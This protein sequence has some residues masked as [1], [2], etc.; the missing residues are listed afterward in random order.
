MKKKNGFF[1]LS[2]VIA[3]FMFLMCTCKKETRNLLVP[4]LDSITVIKITQSTSI[5]KSKILSNNQIGI[6]EKGFCYGTIPKPTVS[7]NKIVAKNLGKMDTV[8]FVDTIIGLKSNT[9]YYVRSYAF[10]ENGVAYSNE[11][12]FTLWINAP[13]PVVTDLDNNNYHSV[14][15]GTQ[16]WMVENLKTTK[17]QNGQSIEN[18][19]NNTQWQYATSGAYCYYDNISAYKYTYGCLYNWSAI[20][21]IRNIAPTGWHVA[22]YD[23]WKNLI[24]FLGGINFVTNKIKEQGTIHWLNHENLST[25]ESGFTALPG[26]YRNYTGDFY[27]I[28][29]AMSFWTSTE[30]DATSGLNFGYTSNADNGLTV[31][32]PQGKMSGNSV[33]CIKN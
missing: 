26:G 3:C 10:N 2:I 19:A 31:L 24:D 21:D 13:G 29:T 5:C 23:D 6:E 14:K 20:A 4:T 28:N 27:Y 12:S 25:N 11:Q 22:T 17:Y 15:I 33:R 8:T 16:I 7:D 1:F 32:A 18:I 30:G 9:T